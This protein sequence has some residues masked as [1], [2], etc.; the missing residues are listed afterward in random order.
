MCSSRRICYVTAIRLSCTDI[1]LTAFISSFQL[2]AKC[3]KDV[4]TN[5][6]RISFAVDPFYILI[7]LDGSR[8]PLKFLYGLLKLKCT[9]TW[10]RV[11]AFKINSGCKRR[12]RAEWNGTCWMWSKV[13]CDAFGE[14]IIIPI[15]Y[16]GFLHELNRARC[17]ISTVHCKQRKFSASRSSNIFI[18]RFWSFRSGFSV[19]TEFSR[20]TE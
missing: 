11:S 16:F 7:K 12:N 2:T 1:T 4:P 8:G 19:F 15:I 6:P 9:G 20:V 17:C 5:P 3:L 10:L 13:Y 18:L 14:R